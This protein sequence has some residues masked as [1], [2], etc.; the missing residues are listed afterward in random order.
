MSTKAN[1]SA[2]LAALELKKRQ[3]AVLPQFFDGKFAKQEEFIAHPSKLKALF[4]TRRFGKSYTAGLYLVK[5]AYENPGCTVLYVAL[6]RDSAKKILWK[7]VLKPI[8]RRFKL[9]IKFNETLLTATLSNGSIIY[10]MGVD[11][12]EDEKDKLLGQKYKLA[13]IDECASFSI[14]LRELVY[15]TLKPAMADLEGTIVMLGTPGNLTK[16]LFYDITTGVEPGWYVYKADTADN[17]FMAKRWAEEIASLIANQP[18]IVETPMFKQ[19]YLGQ[20]VVDENAL[21]YKFN[22]D[23]NQYAN[24]PTHSLGSWQFLLGVDLGY[25]D[26]S[27]FV[28]VAFHEFDKNL[29]VIDTFKQPRMDITD[30]ANKIKHFKTQFDIHKVVIDGANKQAVEEIQKRH[31]IPLISTEKVGKV[32]FIEIMNSEL[33]MGKIKLDAVKAHELADEWQNLVWKE[34]GGKLIQPKVENPACANHL[35]D[36]C[37]YIWRYCYQYLSDAAPKAT[38]PWGTSAWHAQQVEDMEEAAIEHFTRLEEEID[39]FEG[40]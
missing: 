4:A 16:S 27:A 35:S 5:E 36:A 14:N 9:G 24:L 29:Y 26:D 15:G 7:D 31:Q 25:E 18:Y 32:D 1:Y 8:N 40:Y 13:V 6:T 30:V 20:W 17:P 2:S 22:S 12:H 23:R 11:S 38:P 34:K 21:V 33:I 19:M 28:V 39:P 37:L 3:A 10:L